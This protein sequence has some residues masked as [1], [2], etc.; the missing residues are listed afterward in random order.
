MG[1]TF[2]QVWSNAMTPADAAAE[3]DAKANE[4]L[5]KG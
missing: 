4:L 3:I 2:D 5:A 1:P